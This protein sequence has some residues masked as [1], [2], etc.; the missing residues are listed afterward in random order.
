[1]KKVKV[2]LWSMG[3]VLLLIVAG[4]LMT[5]SV[6]ISKRTMT[7]AAAVAI[8]MLVAYFVMTAS[9]LF[10]ETPGKVVMNV[11]IITIP[12]GSCFYW[13]TGVFPVWGVIL[14]A[15]TCVVMIYMMIWWTEEG[16]SIKEFLLFVVIDC[17]L[18]SIAESGIARIIDLAESRWLI[19]LMTAIPWIIL[20]M[21]TGYFLFDII[22]FKEDLGSEDFDPTDYLEEE[23]GI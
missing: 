1:M 10:D 7:A 20:V 23:V 6:M 2:T 21:S 19:G 4:V 13:A 15:L 8:M 16:S 14:G 12:V 18:A 3:A 5:F 9:A 22:K 11:F 17:L